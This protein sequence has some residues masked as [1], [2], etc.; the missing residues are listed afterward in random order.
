MNEW[1]IAFMPMN[2]IRQID[3]NLSSLSELLRGSSRTA[4]VTDTGMGLVITDE[5]TEYLKTYVGPSGIVRSRWE[6]PE[7]GRNGRIRGLS[8]HDTATVA[9]FVDRCVE[10]P[11]FALPGDATHQAMWLRLHLNRQANRFAPHQVHTALRLPQL[12]ASTD[13]RYDVLRAYRR[14]MQNIIDDGDTDAVFG[15]RIGRDLQLLV[16]AIASPAGLALIAALIIDEAERTRSDAGKTERDRRLRYV[17]EDLDY[18]GID[19]AGQLAELIK[20]AVE[21]LSS[22]RTKPDLTRVRAMRSLLTGIINRLPNA[23]LADAGFTRGMA[24]HV[25]ILISWWLGSDLTRLTDAALRLEMLTEGWPNRL[26]ADAGAG[27]G[28]G[29]RTGENTGADIMAIGLHAVGGS[30]ICTRAVRNGRPGWKR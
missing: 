13:A 21:L 30:T 23:A 20:T 28:R 17:V 14:L 19:D 3:I 22:T 16:D 6:Y 24:G 7:P 11:A 15:G 29:A 1:S 5:R 26:G 27:T 12:A 10:L 2:D 18:S 9:T 8:D 4:N 25:L